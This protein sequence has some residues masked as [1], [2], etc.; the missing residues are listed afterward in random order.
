MANWN[1]EPAHEVLRRNEQLRREAYGRNPTRCG[2]C[3]E[4]LT[5][6]QRW[7]KFCSHSCAARKNN[8]GC[9]RHGTELQE[10]SC[11]SCATVYR[12]WRRGKKFCSLKC[13][14]ALKKRRIID[15]WLAGKISSNNAYGM[16]R[17]TIRTWLI[18]RAGG[19]CAQ[20]GWGEVN[21]FSGLPCVQIDH[22]DG[23][24]QNGG[25]EN[26]RVLCPNCHSMTSTFMGLNI[27][28]NEG[29]PFRRVSSVG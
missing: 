26:L 18:N 7:N 3:S 29:R 2:S 4:A 1:W 12:T 21:P 25:P 14:A 27:N 19:K 24:Y 11:Q 28:K 6:K 23:N 5:Y 17:A 9:N 8:I 20:C 13:A 22:K 15:D 16:I 10:R